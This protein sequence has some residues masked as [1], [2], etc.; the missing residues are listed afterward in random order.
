M[1]VL[2]GW[3]WLG[4]DRPP[5]ALE[6]YHRVRD[7]EDPV[8]PG[9]VVE[10]NPPY[11]NQTGR[12]F[13]YAVVLEPVALEPAG[14]GVY[15]RIGFKSTTYAKLWA[16]MHADEIQVRNRYKDD[17]VDTSDIPEAS[18]E[19]FARAKLRQP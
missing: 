5:L 11:I 19:F 3:Q 12:Q 6:V 8:E 18:E 7:G 1:L 14:A 9:E 10:I 13:A 15:L 16:E 2:V 4:E 17:A